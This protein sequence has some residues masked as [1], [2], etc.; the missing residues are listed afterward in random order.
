MVFSSLLFLSIFLPA[1]LALYYLIPK[2]LY[3]NIVLCIASLFFYAWGEPVCIFI[4]IFSILMNYAAGLLMGRFRSKG[5]SGCAKATLIVAIILNLLMLGV[6][7]Y[8]PLVVETLKGI[9]PSLKGMP[10]PVAKQVLYD[11][12]SRRL[13][14]QLRNYTVPAEGMLPIGISFYTFQAMSYVIDVYRGDTAVQ[15]NPMLFGTYVALFPQLIAGPIV[16]YKD[17]EDQ[18]NGRR[19]NVAQVASGVKLFTVGLAKKI[20]IANQMATLWQEIRGAAQP[21]GI[22]GSWI[23]IIAFTIQIYFDFSGYSDMAIGLGRMFGFEFL[24]NFDYPYISESITDFWRRWHISL[25]TWFREYVYIPLGGNRRG[26]PRQILNLLIV[27]SLTGL[28]HGASWN[29][30]LWGLFYGIVLIIEKLFLGKLVKKLPKVFRH[31][32][33]MVIV[34]FG[35]ALF[36][37]TQT[38]ELFSFLG[39]M[40]SFRNGFISHDAL[41]LTLSY[42]PLLL[43]A[44]VGS[45]PLPAKLRHKLDGKPWAEWA[46]I[47]LVLVALAFC[48]ASLVASGYNPFIY[49]RF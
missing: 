8:T 26:M 25:S 16:R 44:A 19:E 14:P 45:T 39:S 15:K 29:F 23:G 46:D 20:L 42:L 18:L 41:V 9:I 2:R 38:G 35:W 21:V 40:F 7:K 28:W 34:I 47:A 33:T 43:V 1:V 49:Y 3:R 36:D 12:L 37:F 27:W 13:I 10:T 32:Y 31:I 6:F 30:V 48:I 11:L 4:M 24:K 22:M 5:R 17:I